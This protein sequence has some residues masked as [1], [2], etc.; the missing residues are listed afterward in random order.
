MPGLH[1][2]KRK[3]GEDLLTEDSSS[4]SKAH[5]DDKSPG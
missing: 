5:V 3:A 1:F 2:T 4:V